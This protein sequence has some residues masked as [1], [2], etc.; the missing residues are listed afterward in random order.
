MLHTARHLMH[1]HFP[2]LPQ[3]PDFT[4]SSFMDDK[5]SIFMNDKSSNKMSSVDSLNNL[6]HNLDSLLNKT[7]SSCMMENSTNSY[8]MNSGIS[9][10]SLPNNSLPN[11]NMASSAFTSTNLK[12]SLTNHNSVGSAFMLTS[13]GSSTVSGKL[14]YSFDGVICYNMFVFFSINDFLNF[15]LLIFEVKGKVVVNFVSE[16]WDSNFAD[17]VEKN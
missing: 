9:S 12:P 17:H 10:S 7:P 13:G 8:L 1:E 5:S 11:H 2:S 15:S 4:S 6:S 3:V 14:V 16:E